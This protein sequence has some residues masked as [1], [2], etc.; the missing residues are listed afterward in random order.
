MRRWR[1]YG[2]KAGA[3]AGAGARGCEG[4]E[5][6]KGCIDIVSQNLLARHCSSKAR[7]AILDPVA[8]GSGNCP[9]F[10]G[11]VDG[12]GGGVGDECSNRGVE[13]PRTGGGIGRPGGGRTERAHC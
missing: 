3:G 5:R 9:G 11:S 1:I 12:A 6:S 7:A 8:F 10:V 4:S 13:G 2:G